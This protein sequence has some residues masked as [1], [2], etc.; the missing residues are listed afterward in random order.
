MIDDTLGKLEARI[1]ALAAVPD[2][3]KREL[4]GLF[5]TLRREVTG[6]SETETEQAESIARFAELSAHEAT[7][8]G[9]NPQL[10]NLSRDGLAVSVEGFEVSH[11]K[12]VEIVNAICVN[13]SNLGI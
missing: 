8:P 9:G 2:E 6:L 10:Q 4:I 1:G 13:L 5:E 7:R 12:L 3:K 11:P